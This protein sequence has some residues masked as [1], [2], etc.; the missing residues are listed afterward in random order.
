MLKYTEIKYEIN[1]SVTDDE[2]LEYCKKYLINKFKLNKN[3][4]SEI[5]LFKKSI[6]ARK[7]VMYSLTVIFGLTKMSEERFF[8]KFKNN[9]HLEKYLPFQ[10]EIPTMKEKKHYLVVGMGPAGLFN[11]LILARS[12]AL[13]T[14]IDRGK[15]VEERVKDVNEFFEKG[16]LKKDSNVQFGEGGAGTFSDGKLNTGNTTNLTYEVLKLFVQ[17]GANP[18]ILYE[19]KPHIGTDELRKIIKNIRVELERLGATVLFSTKLTKIKMENH[20]LVAY[21][22]SV[23]QE[24]NYDGI[25]LGVGHSATD[26]YRML[27]N[28][29]ITLKPKSFAIG[30]RIEHPQSLINESL[31]KDKAKFLPAAPYK[32][33][34]HL[35]NNRAAYSFCMCP[36]GYVVN[37]SSEENHLVV[38]G[39][40]N[41]KR[42]GI[43]ANSAILVEIKPSDYYLGSPLDGLEYQRKLEETVF[44]YAKNYDVPVQRYI[45]FKNK[46]S[47]KSVSSVYPTVKPGFVTCNLYDILPNWLCDS[48]NEAISN[49]DKKL[50]N[51]AYDDAILSAVETRSSSP[52]QI[53]RDEN[54]HSS[55]KHIYPIGE[56]SGYSGGIMT[57]AVDGIKCALKIIEEV[58]NGKQ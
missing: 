31:Y 42:D 5:R 19:A 13:V 8:L 40:S 57:S 6:D 37:A 4:I 30:V 23:Q 10:L 20:Q 14:I 16:I 48:L 36:G 56:G 46:V 34:T 45:D 39:M 41:S 55:M 22:E 52:V 12:G 26:T 33:V 21:F 9:R 24:Q 28:I 58:N 7:N 15:P 18:N 11:A 29:G 50:K 49:F 27:E 3:D 47:S 38:N 25:I 53:T 35:E 17:F 32:L 44:N 1:S 51:F 2:L 43:N 54:Y